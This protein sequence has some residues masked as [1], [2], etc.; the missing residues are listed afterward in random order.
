MADGS[1]D[2]SLQSECQWT[3]MTTD[4]RMHSTKTYQS[5]EECKQLKEAQQKMELI[6]TFT[7][8]KVL[9]Q[10]ANQSYLSDE[11]FVLVPILN[12]EKIKKDIL[13]YIDK[14]YHN[15]TCSLLW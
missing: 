3:L 10:F 12:N 4:F 8:A 2:V 5:L 14:K 13:I 1:G 7:V 15:K 6:T 9:L 11:K